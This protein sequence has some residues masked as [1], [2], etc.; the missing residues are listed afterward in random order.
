MFSCLHHTLGVEH[1]LRFTCC[2]CEPLAVTMVRAR[3]WPASPRFPQLAFTFELLDWAEVLLLEC[4]VALSDFCRALYFKC[5]FLVNEVCC[6]MCGPLLLLYFTQRKDIYA[7]MIDAFEE[8]RSEIIAFHCA[9]RDVKLLQIHEN[10]N[11][12]PEFCQC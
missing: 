1:R 8:Y 12:K 6:Y 11:A 4:Q 10:G 2:D 7:A 9:C 3:L 5:P